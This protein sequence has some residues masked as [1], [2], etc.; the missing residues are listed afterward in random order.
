[1]RRGSAEVRAERVI[2]EELRREGWTEADL[3]ARRKSDPVKLALAARLRRETTLTM[4]W[5]AARLQTGTRQ[6]TTTRLQEL[7]RQRLTER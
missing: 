4:A 1:M 5:I 3:V 7:K 2:A 6:S